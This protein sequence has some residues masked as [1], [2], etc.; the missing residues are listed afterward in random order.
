VIR[1]GVVPLSVLDHGGGGSAV[2]LL[3]GGGRSGLD[4][5]QVAERLGTL[6]YRSVA[7]DT[8]GLSRPAVVGHSP[9]G[10]VVALWAAGH[11]SC[12]LW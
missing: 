1:S 7:V 12:P 2:V 8:L 4:G 9:G 3:H 5:D 10:M 11:R 6:D